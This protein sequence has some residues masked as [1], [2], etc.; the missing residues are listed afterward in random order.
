MIYFLNEQVIVHF[1]CYSRQGIWTDIVSC[2]KEP[3]IMEYFDYIIKILTIV[4]SILAI[5]K[6]YKDL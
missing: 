6:S 2:R 3:M 5:Y 1:C 4:S